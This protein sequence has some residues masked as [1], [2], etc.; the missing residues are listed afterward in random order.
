MNVVTFQKNSIEKIVIYLNESQ[1]ITHANVS[2]YFDKIVSFYIIQHLCKYLIDQK[3]HFRVLQ[4]DKR[5]KIDS[6]IVE[7]L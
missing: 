4:D 5:S 3:Y 1:N 7:A 2:T 6:I